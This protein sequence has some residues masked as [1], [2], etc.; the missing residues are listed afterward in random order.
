MKVI[1]W[2]EA[3]AN[4]RKLGVEKIS[5]QEWLNYC[6][7]TLKINANSLKSKTLKKLEEVEGL[8]KKHGGFA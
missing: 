5:S 3:A 4:K 7:Q 1:N 6:R 2:K 8:I